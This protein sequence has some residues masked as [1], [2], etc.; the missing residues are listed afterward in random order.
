MGIK[1][2]KRERGTEIEGE[3]EGERVYY[4]KGIKSTKRRINNLT[5]IEGT[6]V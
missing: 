5:Y 6:G 3:K 2:E 4:A 1:T